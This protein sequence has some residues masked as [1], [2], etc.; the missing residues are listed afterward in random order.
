MAKSKKPAGANGGSGGDDGY[1][2]GYRK[3]PKAG[4]FKKGQSGNPGGRKKGTLN[5]KTIYAEVYGETM[6]LAV[7]GNKR[8]VNGLVA[9]VMREFQL[10]MAGDGRIIGQV[11]N[12][13]ER[14][15]AGEQSSDF[16][17]TSDEDR[18]IIERAIRRRGSAAERG[19]GAPTGAPS[20]EG[21]LDGENGDVDV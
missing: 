19:S 20:D 13:F 16:E 12:R 7:N 3:P 8:A 15:G 6:E 9:M 10:G 1:D 2:V 21:D 17:E 4:Q 18:A 5:L 11:L 14:F